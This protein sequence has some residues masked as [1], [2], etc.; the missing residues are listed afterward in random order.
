MFTEMT[1][2]TNINVIFAS[3]YLS[4]TVQRTQN[5]CYKLQL[6]CILN[7]YNTRHLKMLHTTLY[8]KAKKKHTTETAWY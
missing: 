7:R 8:M 6:S 1:K 4:V 2:A 3:Q 5:S